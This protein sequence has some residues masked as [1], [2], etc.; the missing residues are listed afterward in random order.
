MEEKGWNYRGYVGSTDKSS[1]L[2]FSRSSVVPRVGRKTDKGSLA[3][4]WAVTGL[5]GARHRSDR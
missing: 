1:L 5:T 4:P 2:N 3:R